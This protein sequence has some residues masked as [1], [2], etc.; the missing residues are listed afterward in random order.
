MW[1]PDTTYSY[2]PNIGGDILDRGQSS[3]GLSR[4][5]VF[6]VCGERY[7]LEYGENAVD[8]DTLP[9]IA[10]WFIRGSALHVAFSH[11]WL[12]SLGEY[13]WAPADEAWRMYLAERHPDHP[14]ILDIVASCERL[15]PLL[16]TFI[17][18]EMTDWVPVEIEEELEYVT[19]AG[20]RVTARLDVVLL[21]RHTNELC[22]VDLKTSSS[23]HSSV[24]FKCANSRQFALFTKLAPVLAERYGASTVTYAVLSGQFLKRKFAEPEFEYVTPN[25]TIVA[26]LDFYIDKTV[27]AIGLGGF[28]KV[29]DMFVCGSNIPGGDCPHMRRCYG[30]G[31]KDAESV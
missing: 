26:D 20:T 16:E 8:Q 6:N 3:Y 5:G 28:Y 30:F 31:K 11:V 25:P 24:Q 15:W 21:N 18:T 29:M 17:G 14:K 27:A 22:I 19:P 4:L 1:L 12:R 7:D 9:P 2:T 10:P 13:H 23:T